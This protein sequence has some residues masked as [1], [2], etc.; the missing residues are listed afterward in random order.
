VQLFILLTNKKLLR[1]VLT[2]PR[3]SICVLLTHLLIFYFRTLCGKTAEPSLPNRNRRCMPTVCVEKKCWAFS[4]SCPLLHWGGK[5]TYFNPLFGKGRVCRRPLCRNWATFRNF[6][7]NLSWRDSLI[8]FTSSLVKFHPWET[9]LHALLYFLVTYARSYTTAWNAV[10]LVVV[11]VNC[12]FCRAM[13]CQRGLCRYAVSVR[14][15][16]TWILSK[17]VIASTIFFHCRV[18]TPL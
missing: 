4:G 6:K 8:M 5:T 13:L 11:V 18:A 12:G 17:R 3:L 2:P 1:I 15:S 16:R 14:P 10:T 9:F 7:T